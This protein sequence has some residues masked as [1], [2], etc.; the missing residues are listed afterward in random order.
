MIRRTVTLVVMILALGAAWAAEVQVSANPSLP[1]PNL[2]KNPGFEAVD[3]QGQP[4]QWTFGTANPENFEQNWLPEG[5][6]GPGSLRVMARTGIMSGYWNQSVPVKPNTDYVLRVWYR[7]GGGKMLI[8]AH[9]GTPDGKTVDQRFW[10][11]SMRS[12]YL[13]PAFLRPE[14]M[15]GGD[16]NQWRLCRLPFKTLPNMEWIT[17]SLGI[18]FSG[19]EVWFDDA[20]VTEATTDL[21][22]RVKGPVEKLRV[23][24]EEGK[25]LFETGKSDQ[26]LDK[27]LP[28]V[29]ADGVYKIEVTEPGG[30]VRTVLYL[31]EVAK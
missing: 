22:V 7:L 4:A 19:G 18:F 23:L 31:E 15:K 11:S 29:P 5:R 9:G 25:A 28:G 6:S 13:V 17:V 26:G 10:D 12:H 8:Y 27:T 21:T 1:L 30:N 14:Y 20:S 24:D 16:A 3:A 2:V